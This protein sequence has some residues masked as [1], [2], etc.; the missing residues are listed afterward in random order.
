MSIRKIEIDKNGNIINAIE[1]NIDKDPVPG[2]GILINN[3]DDSFK[4]HQKLIENFDIMSKV[5]KYDKETKKIKKC[6]FEEFKEKKPDG[7]QKQYDD[8]ELPPKK[9][10]KHSKV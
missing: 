5:L 4:Y 6:S 10:L 2:I 3:D 1:Y 9:F 8:V 7:T